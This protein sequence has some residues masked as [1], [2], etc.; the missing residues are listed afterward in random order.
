MLPET[1]PCL[2][3]S[4]LRERHVTVYLVSGERDPNRSDYEGS[5]DEEEF[6]AAAMPIDNGD[7]K[8]YGTLAKDEYNMFVN[9]REPVT[10]TTYTI[11]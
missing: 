10:K 9:E 5:V 8:K 11:S 2:C 7:T 6:T 4:S 1:A 3:W